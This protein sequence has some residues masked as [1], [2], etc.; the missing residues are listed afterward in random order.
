MNDQTRLERRYRRLLAWYP[1]AFRDEHEEEIL[2]VLMAAARSRPSAPPP[3]DSVNLITNAL[4]MRA[5]PRA[6]RSTPTV[7]WAVRLMV[8][9][10]ALELVALV[11]VALT[12]GDLVATIARRYPAMPAAH[13]AHVVSAQVLGIAVG[14]PIAAALW[15]WLAWSSDRGHGWARGL[16]GALFGLTSV[17]LLAAL[18]RGAVT[19]APADVIAGGALWLVALGALGLILSPRPADTS[20]AEWTR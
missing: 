6:P 14:A 7:F 11:T 19:L 12:R 17:S 15:L 18:G 2:A 1:R 5:R 8:L 10:A 4:L 9:G 20:S 13:V 3:A 16:A